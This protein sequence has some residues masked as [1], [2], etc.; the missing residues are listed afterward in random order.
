MSK[1]QMQI[2]KLLELRSFDMCK[3]TVAPIIAMLGCLE[4]DTEVSD[5]GIETAGSN[6]Y[7]GVS[8]KDGDTN[9]VVATIREGVRF[10]CK[11]EQKFINLMNYQTS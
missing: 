2:S 11:D 5:V 1:E 4:L 9:G 8:R 6:D 10:S 3:N 7:R